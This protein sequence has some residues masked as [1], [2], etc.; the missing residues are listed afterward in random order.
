MTDLSSKGM[1]VFDDKNVN[2]ANL[3]I[4]F[5]VKHRF[6]YVNVFYL[7]PYK[8]IE[9]IKITLKTRTKGTVIKKSILMCILSG[10]S[11]NILK[12]NSL[13]G[14]RFRI[15]ISIMYKIHTITAIKLWT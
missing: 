12:F 9:R 8:Y 10:I 15:E 11:H 7:L 5:T 3:K 2:K 13:K 14:T 4:H 6:Y 1:W